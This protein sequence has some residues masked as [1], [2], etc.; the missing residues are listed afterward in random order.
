MFAFTLKNA[1]DETADWYIDLKE[2]GSVGKGRAPEGKK[3]N[4][5]HAI[6]FYDSFFTQQ[7]AGYGICG[8]VRTRS[9]KQGGEFRDPVFY[10]HELT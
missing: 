8:P 4:G 1:Q 6:P 2:S 5:T 3:A 9:L 7:R 10:S